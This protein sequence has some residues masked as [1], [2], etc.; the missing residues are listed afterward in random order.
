MDVTNVQAAAYDTQSSTAAPSNPTDKLANSQVFLQM[1][2]AQIKNQ[3][4]LNPADGVQFMTQ[5]AQ[6]SQLE[7]LI[8]I[9]KDLDTATTPS[10]PTTP[11]Q[12]A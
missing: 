8:G 5:L 7:Q 10:Q 9:R 6:F 2:V 12:G 3:N 4:P 11:K 1:L